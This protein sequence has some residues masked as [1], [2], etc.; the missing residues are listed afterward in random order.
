MAAT[1]TTRPVP[2]R[3]PRREALAKIKTEVVRIGMNGTREG[4]RFA[5]AVFRACRELREA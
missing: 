1:M 3:S 4:F 2:S 5:Q